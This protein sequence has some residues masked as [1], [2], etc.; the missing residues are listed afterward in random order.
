MEGSQFVIITIGLLLSVLLIIGGALSFLRSR[1]QKDEDKDDLSLLKSSS[2]S[3][4]SNRELEQLDDELPVPDWLKE[5]SEDK[6][7]QPTRIG[8]LRRKLP[9]DVILLTRD[10][11]TDEWHVEVD[12]QHYRRLSD[13]HDDNAA[14]KIL[15]ALEGMK[16]F[17]GLGTQQLKQS[18]APTPRQSMPP[19]SRKAGLAT[20]PAP[21]GS[22]IAQIDTVLQRELA[23][24]PD[25]AHRNIHMGT[26]P[27]GSLLI[28]VDD[29]FYRAPEEIS[30]QRVHDLIKF[31]IHTWE[32]SS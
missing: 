6:S 13:V 5:E 24:H 20:Y 7:K 23:L 1:Q 27:D 4:P 19:A 22:I 14:T 8:D 28:E 21:K 18:S 31:A 16:A 30:D 11:E 9:P 29:D 12:G 26:A 32:R 2:A 25:V 17:A 10:E 15:N 3:E